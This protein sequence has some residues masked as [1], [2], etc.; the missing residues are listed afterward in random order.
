MNAPKRPQS[1]PDLL[2]EIRRAVQDGIA[3]MSRELG[4]LGTKV[5]RL[6]ERLFVGTPERRSL[7]EEVAQIQ[8]RQSMAPKSPDLGKQLAAI[9]IAIVTAAGAMWGVSTA[10]GSE[11]PP[12]SAAP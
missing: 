11:P 1:S 4:E 2:E 3:P 7:Q 9:V 6:E 5:D 12:A 10:K 8:A